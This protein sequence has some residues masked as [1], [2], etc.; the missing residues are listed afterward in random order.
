MP[1]SKIVTSAAVVFFSM[2]FAAVAQN[3]SLPRLDIQKLCGSRAKAM[4]DL[5]AVTANALDACIRSEQRARAAL[6]AAWKDIPPFYKTSCIRPNDFAASYEEWIAC[7][8][9]N[10]DMKSL[11]SKN[12]SSR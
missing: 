2:S 1:K 4:G 6:I 5:G 10:I 8:E 7:L 3:D 11:H 9:L 12:D